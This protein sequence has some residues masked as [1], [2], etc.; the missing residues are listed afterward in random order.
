MLFTFQKDL[1]SKN[2]LLS[3]FLNEVSTRNVH[4]NQEKYNLLGI[5]FIILLNNK[6]DGEKVST[7]N[8]KKN[9]KRKLVKKI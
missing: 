5:W 2:K 7:I 6:F 8:I 3:S 1:F 4:E 9:I